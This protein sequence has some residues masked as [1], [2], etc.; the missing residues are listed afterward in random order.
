MVLFNLIIT[1]M[2]SIEIGH[3]HALYHRRHDF[4]P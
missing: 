4:I 3:I 2:S 1:L